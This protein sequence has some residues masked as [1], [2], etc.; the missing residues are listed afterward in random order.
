MGS[1]IPSVSRRSVKSRMSTTAR[2]L[3]LTLMI[4]V[5]CAAVVSAADLD[6]ADENII[7]L[8][9]SDKQPMLGDSSGMRDAV[10][11][12]EGDGMGM[13][14]EAEFREFTHKHAKKYK[15]H[16]EFSRR[17]GVW[18]DNLSF[19]R[20]WNAKSSGFQVG[21]NEFA[22]LTD[23]EFASSYLNQNLHDEYLQSETFTNSLLQESV[24]SDSSS[25]SSLTDGYDIR[26]HKN[27]GSEPSHQDWTKHG[28]VS[29][30]NNHAKCFACYAFAAC[31]A[32]E[33][34]VKLKTG[35]LT[36]LSAQQIVDCS[37]PSSGFMNHGC[38][39]GTMVKSYKYIIKNGLM[40][41]E[42]YG[43]RTELNSRPECKLVYS[44]CK[45]K[46]HKVAQKIHGYVNIQKGS[47][48]D[49]KNAVGMRP[50]SAAIDAHHRP[51]KL[52]RSGV[53]SLASCTTH[54]THGLLVVG[55]G[56]DKGRKYWKVKNSWG[57]TWGQNGYGKVIR[58]KNMCAIGN[59]ANYPIIPNDKVSTVRTLAELR[60]TEEDN[61]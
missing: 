21:M 22:D 34:A 44:K 14:E 37:T 3:L 48:G 20:K 59:W 24:G 26:W 2:P 6:D 45:F 11:T 47:E 55:Y 16:K 32:I 61:P 38:N 1:H 57:T 4:C 50:V 17:F 15:D 25:D 43:Y 9:E 36:K 29:A 10:T 28:A 33:G 40:K 12:L 52:Y 5:T 51:F 23:E 27:T 13:D 19:V 60:E 53:F 31:G 58:D 42:D 49:L 39:G 18:K 35:K 30:V 54:L 41:W 8:L 56:T 7:E 46:K